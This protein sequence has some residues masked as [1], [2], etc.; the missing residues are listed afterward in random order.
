MNHLHH[1]LTAAEEYSE[2]LKTD[3][4]SPSHARTSL[5]SFLTFLIFIS[6]LADTSFNG[7]SQ[8][9]SSCTKFLRSSSSR[10]LHSRCQSVT[11]RQP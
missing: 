4:I 5:L 9:Q 2:L 8:A 6:T 1:Y 3:P 11:Q 10:P 7:T